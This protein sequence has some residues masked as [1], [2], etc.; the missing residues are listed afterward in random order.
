M[1]A[2]QPE[3]EKIQK[4]Y[5]ANRDVLNQKTMELYKKHN[6]N[7]M[8]SCLGMLLNMVLTMVVFFTL[9]SGL[10]K[11][12]SYK[13]YTEYTTLQTTYEQAVG[14]TLLEVTENDVTTV[15]IKLP[16]ETIIELTEEKQAE[17][18]FY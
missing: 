2:I 4:R 15:K 7:V 8:G 9:F 11:I 16:N 10:N 14:G 13:I 6:Y 3:L 1:A 18:Y 12:A 17:A 5:S